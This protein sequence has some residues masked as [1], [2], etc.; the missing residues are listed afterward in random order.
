LAHVAVAAIAAVCAL[1]TV[2]GCGGSSKQAKPARDAL[3][4]DSRTLILAPA[5]PLGRSMKLLISPNL[6]WYLGQ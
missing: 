1:G 2:A 5:G 3:R 4:G 6:K